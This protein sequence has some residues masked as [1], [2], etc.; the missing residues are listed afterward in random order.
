MIVVIYAVPL[1]LNV[2]VAVAVPVKSMSSAIKSVTSSL[3]AIVT[4]NASFCTVVGTSVIVTVGLVM[5]TV[6]VFCVAGVL[7]LP[8]VSCATFSA[9]LNTALPSAD[10]VILAP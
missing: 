4:S 10:G 1:P 3:K 7:L 2:A 6:T 5:S 8:A 9:T